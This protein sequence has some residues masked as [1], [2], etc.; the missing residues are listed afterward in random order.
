MRQIYSLDVETKGISAEWQFASLEPWRVR[1]GKAFITSLAVCN[2]DGETDM[3][4]RADYDSSEMFIEAIIQMLTALEGQIVYCHNAV[5]D[6]AFLIATLQPQRC[7]LIPKCIRKIRWHDTMLL[8]KWVVNGQR[9]DQMNFSYSLVNLCQNFLDE[10]PRLAEF[11]EEKSKPFVWNDDTYWSNRNVLDVIFTQELAVYMED[12]LHELQRNGYA[13]EMKNI[14][15]VANGWITGIRIDQTR[16]P[17]VRE[18]FQKE[19]ND[20]IAE[21]GL[22]PSMITSPKQLGHY[23]FTELAIKPKSY[24][25][26]GAPRTAADD[27][28][29]IAYEANISGDTTM[30]KLLNGIKRYKEL[31]TLMSKY[32]TGME[33][34]LAHTQD[35]YIY[36]APRI[37]GTYTGR[38]T[39]SSKTLDTYQT[40][41]ALHQIPRKDKDVRSL[42]IAP[43]GMKI[44]EADASGQESR[45]M[46]IRSG[47]FA[48]IKVFNDGM[49]FHSMTGSNI[50]GQEYEEFVAKYLTGDK[51]AIEDRQMGKLTNL[52]CNYRIGGKALS[53]KAFDDYDIV[54]PIDTGVFLVSTFSRT[55]PGV[56]MYWDDAIALARATGYA[57]TFGGR[58][59][60]IH[61][62]SYKW[63]WTSESSAINVPIQGS[64]AAMKNI[65]ITE[66]HEN[67]EEAVF[68]L[69]LHDATFYYV[70]DE[71]F[72]PKIDAVLENIKYEDYWGFV[73]SVKLPYES[74]IG[75]SWAEVK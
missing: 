62:W 36:G 51:R 55:Y 26:K 23:L 42:M 59:Y 70:P 7:G 32:V 44:Y 58:R 73:P 5:F 38:F 19:M 8:T 25:P 18:K 3:I 68:V 46:A 54:F 21:T 63:K 50:V 34:A 75:N 37:F 22:N 31:A 72:K 57:E 49:D 52:S 69:D 35:G 12:K 28:K 11:V 14:V 74:K 27:I 10:H 29:L 64:G 30:A 48:M 45:L 13:T 53:R 47:D 33:N 39:Y 16:V 71:S 20:I 6:L 9:A 4:A 66:V 15:P 43:P 41:I 2:P 17:I 1:Q 61:D 65:A 67:V 40:S 24:T 56:P 60:K